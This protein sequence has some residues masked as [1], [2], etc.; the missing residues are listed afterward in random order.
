MTKIG[1]IL[2]FFVSMTICGLAQKV[3]VSA[4][5]NNLLYLEVDNPLTIAVE[6]QSCKNIIVTTDNGIITGENGSYNCKPKSIGAA[7]IIVGVKQNGKVKELQRLSFRVKYLVPIENI[8][9]IIANC[10]KDCK[11]SKTVLLQQKLVRAQVINMEINAT[12]PVDL[13]TVEINNDGSV[14]TFSNTGDEISEEIQKEF[15]LLKNSATVHF[16]EIY[17]HRPDGNVFPLSSIKLNI[18]E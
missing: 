5:K 14:K 4:D 8:Q 6:S 11:M 7:N 18:T 9:F 12:Y 2:T 15:A 10:G 17:T 1:L 3:A 16:K 13:F